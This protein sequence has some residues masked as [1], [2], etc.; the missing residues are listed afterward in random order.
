MF[1][2]PSLN[3]LLIILPIVS[4]NNFKRFSL[5]K[6]KVIYC[7]LYFL[8]CRVRIIVKS[9]FYTIKTLVFSA[10]VLPLRSNHTFFKYAVALIITMNTSRFHTY[11]RILK[12]IEFYSESFF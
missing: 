5:E 4:I 8:W 1:R 9:S 2:K 10:K 11:I 6:V 3:I 7:L 12:F